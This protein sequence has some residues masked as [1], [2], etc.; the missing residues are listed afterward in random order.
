MKQI[1]SNEDISLFCQELALLLHAGVG[2]GDALALL[3]EEEKEKDRGFLTALAEQV[4]AGSSLGD[5]LSQS[6][7]F[8]PYLCGLVSV[9]EKTGRTEEALAALSDYYEQRVRLNRRIR[10]AL[11][12]PAVMLALMLVVIGILLIKVLPIFDDVYAS[13]GGRLTGVAG[14]LLALGRGLERALPVLWILLAAAV[15]FAL[16]FTFVKPLRAKLTLWWQEKHGD[17]GISRKLNNARLAQAMAMGMAS[18]LPVEEAVTLSANLMEGGAKRRCL[19]CGERLEKGEALSEAL[20]Q[21]GLLPPR[22]CRILELGQRGGVADTSMAKIA[23]ELMEEGETALDAMVS[24][25]EPALVLVCSLLVGLILL[26]VMLPLMN[27][28]AAIG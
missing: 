4:D 27:I 17:K 13:L 6:G 7:A 11:L 15:L 25:V 22:Q 28:M 16:L 26:S 10:S 14:G 21:S 1:L 5:A 18:G 12:Y 9:G 20:N 2:T 3:A 19:D 8:P 23:Q 24:R